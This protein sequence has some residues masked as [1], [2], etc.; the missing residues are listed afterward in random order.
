M[1][2]VE[3][4]L[5][6]QCSD[7]TTTALIQHFIDNKRYFP[8]I[9]VESFRKKSAEEM[10]D[11]LLLERNLDRTVISDV[12][13]ALADLTISKKSEKWV[14]R[15]SMN[16]GDCQPPPKFKW[17]AAS[18]ELGIKKGYCEEDLNYETEKKEEVLREEE[19]IPLRLDD[20]E[21]IFLPKECNSYTLSQLR[22]HAK[23][24][25]KS[26]S[27]LSEKSNTDIMKMTRDYLCDLIIERR[28]GI[29]EGIKKSA[30]TFAET[31][32]KPLIVPTESSKTSKI[33]LQDTAYMLDEI[34]CK[35]GDKKR[36]Q[37]HMLMFKKKGYFSS[38]SESKIK[39]F[40]LEQLCNILFKSRQVKK[41][42]VDEDKK[43]PTTMVVQQ[44]SIL[45]SQPMFQVC[46]DTLLSDI[47]K[48]ISIYYEYLLV[49][50]LKLAPFGVREG[51]FAAVEEKE[52]F[53]S[54]V[55]LIKN[56]LIIGPFIT[57]HLCEHI[58]TNVLP[59][60]KLLKYQKTNLVDCENF[61]GSLYNHSN[62]EN[63][64]KTMM[65]PSLKKCIDLVCKDA[66]VN[67]S[68]YLSESCVKTIQDCLK[69]CFTFIAYSV[70]SPSEKP[71]MDLYLGE[72][73]SEIKK[74]F[75]SI[76]PLYDAT[77]PEMNK[78]LM[79][80]S[81]IFWI[82]LGGTDWL[83][84]TNVDIYDCLMSV[85]ILIGEYSEAELIIKEAIFNPITKETEQTLEFKQITETMRE[86]FNK[87]EVYP[88]TDML[89]RL[90]NCIYVIGQNEDCVKYCIDE[91]RFKMFSQFIGEFNFSSVIW[92][93]SE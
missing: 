43:L 81:C 88:S 24:Y 72:K 6:G 40:T 29:L 61:A 73:P 11:L 90:A 76:W 74:R 59:L 54:S 63:K 91:N 28:E 21:S 69:R 10:C 68:T 79:I 46:L 25:K 42:T 27:E 56:R 14:K 20:K 39:N 13:E 31:L 51:Y 9:S 82:C 23:K 2:T 62:I 53:H 65:D 49:P 60:E 67:Q 58:L 44:E 26:F 22:E 70:K 17:T 57:G 3:S 30:I 5:K 89:K 34:I 37:E 50:Q 84:K 38:L 55:F 75:N 87:A 4:L 41:E 86:A 16:K 45:K 12:V 47:C 36:L 85:R 92:L 15:S 32:S 35:R 83:E 52:E 8:T 71:T 18:K 77:S 64:L 1:S 7:Y 80:S 33:E 19:K 66:D 93:D 48:C 78:M